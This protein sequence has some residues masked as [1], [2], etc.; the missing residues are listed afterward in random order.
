MSVVRALI[1]LRLCNSDV[2]R[3]LAGLAEADENLI[4]FL[5]VAPIPH[6]NV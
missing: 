1:R 2:V 5:L 6:H 3:E 4:V